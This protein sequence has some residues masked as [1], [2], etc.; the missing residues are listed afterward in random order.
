MYP[1]E[2]VELITD[3]ALGEF[4]WV[5]PRI[6]LNEIPA[7]NVP[8]PADDVIDAGCSIVPAVAPDGVRPS[9]RGK[10]PGI[11]ASV[12][13]AIV[14]RRRPDPHHRRLQA[15]VLE[16]LEQQ[17]AAARVAYADWE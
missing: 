14:R 4:L 3:P 10:R 11:V 2:R 8:L 7:G 1:P 13:G 12:V 16:A 6:E 5:R 15:I 17:R 9:A